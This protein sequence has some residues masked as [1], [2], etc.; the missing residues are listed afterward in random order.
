LLIDAYTYN[1]LVAMRWRNV[2]MACG[3]CGFVGLSDKKLLQSM[4]EVM[5]HRGPD[6]TNYFVSD[7]VGLGI[8]R[9]SI[10]DLTTGT[11]PIH[12]EDESLWIVY[13]GEIY[14]YLELKRELES[15]GHKFY[16]NSDTEVIVHAYEEWQESCPIHLR[17]MFAFALWDSGNRKLYLARD[18][19][20]K[21]PLFYTQIDNLFLFS[22]EL[23][24]LLQFDGLKRELNYEAMDYYFTFTYIPSPISIFKNVYKLPPASYA[25]YENGNLIV[26]QYWDINFDPDYELDEDALVTLL[27]SSIE[28]AVR[29]RLRSDVPLGAFLSGGIDSSTI[30][31]FMTRL[32]KSPVKTI[33]I[34]FDDSLSEV[35]YSRQVADYLQTD[36]HEH[37]VT[38]R[39]FEILPKLVWHFDEPFADHSMIPTYYLSEVTR[40]QV[41][42]AL[43]GDGGDEMFMGY[44]FLKDPPLYGLYSKVPNSLR[45]VALKAVLSFPINGS[46][47]RMAHHAYEKN[48]GNQSP[49][50]RYAMRVSLFNRDGLKKIY[51][52]G[53]LSHYTPID[54][55]SYMIKLFN[56]QRGSRILDELD[57]AT[58]RSYLKEDILTKVDRMSMATSLEVRCPFLDQGLVSLVE[59]IPADLKLNGRTTK[60]IFKKMVAKRNLLPHDIAFRKKQGFGAPVHNWIRKEW[61]EMVD[62]ILDPVITKNYAGFFNKEYV[63]SMLREPYLNSNRLF[64]L[65]I[66]LVWYKLYIERDRPI[67]LPNRFS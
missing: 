10:I 15:K 63:K 22:S 47:K 51:S 65:I 26:R 1:S 6:E 66:F 39:A 30:V 40:R 67:T 29:V 58:I 33:S 20:G 17:G 49:F 3:I 34:G 23:K 48:Y 28:E 38:P 12:N 45:K 62:Q 60:Y 61:K 27:Y 21:K 9:L 41:K 50:E 14:N 44:P 13:N 11:Q 16:T 5:K 52:H 35:K 7:G 43:S 42:V 31:S 32:S 19:F 24:A 4:C 18:R 25:I 53:F 36:H 8:N 2:D 57:Y 46:Y 55:Y 64:S 37:I 54:A 59:K 56:R